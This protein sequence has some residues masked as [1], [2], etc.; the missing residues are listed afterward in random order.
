MQTSALD[1]SPTPRLL[2]LPEP[3]FLL[4]F[5]TAQAKLIYSFPLPLH[6][7][8]PLPRLTSFFEQTFPDCA[9]IS[10]FSLLGQLCSLTPTALHGTPRVG[11]RKCEADRVI[12]SLPCSACSCAQ[13]IKSR[14]LDGALP[15]TPASPAPV[16]CLN[17][18]ATQIGRNSS[19]PH[20]CL[21]PPGFCSDY[22]C[23]VDHPSPG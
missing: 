21:K 8:K 20:C 14:F 22:I 17:E 15:A 16:L 12:C 3:L 23:H 5:P 7:V 4:L 9:H 1:K 19:Y 18:P 10:C 6:L 13:R 2:S 11:S